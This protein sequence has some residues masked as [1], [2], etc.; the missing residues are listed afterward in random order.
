MKKWCERR[1]S[2]P[3]CAE[4]ET[5]ASSIG[6]HSQESELFIP[7][8][9]FVQRAKIKAPEARTSVDAEPKGNA[10]FRVLGG[11]A[12][13]RRVELNHPRRPY[14]ERAAPSVGGYW[15]RDQESN[16]NGRGI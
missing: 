6:L 16:L 9:F 8:R 10:E 11:E 14:E 7:V 4:F 1:D 5:A 15:L 12:W 13:S 3:H 2:N